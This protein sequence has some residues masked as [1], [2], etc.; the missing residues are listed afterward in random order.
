MT[1]AP[2]AGYRERMIEV[3][4]IGEAELERF[5]AGRTAVSPRDPITAAAF[6]D[7]RRQAEDMAWFLAL[8]DG[9][10]VGGG[11]VYVG[12]HS[13][14]GVGS[15]E[16]WTLAE[17]R[18]RGVGQ[19]LY[20]EL[21]R[22]ATDRGCVALDTR[23]QAD[24]PAGLAWTE[25]RGFRRIGA[26]SAST[27][28]L[29]S[30]AVPDVAPPDGITI[31]SWAERP[32]IEHALYTVFCEAT[33]DIP[34]QAGV[35][36][37]SFERWLANDMRGTSDRPDAVFVALAGDEVVGYAKLS[38]DDGDP[39]AAWND[40]CGV[41]RAWRGRGVAGALKRAQIAWAMSQ[42]LE[43]LHARNELANE[44]IRR[45]NERLGYLTEPGTIL[46]R[47]MLSSPD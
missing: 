15:A 39:E 7:W 10:D 21:L 41:R 43:R 22:W 47:T 23:V 8:E 34:G 6:A 18:G 19:A 4:E 5:V 12:W 31:Q 36:V 14:P 11:L 29:S 13:E 38:L 33:R 25:R 9:R 46:L 37:P 27:L 3:V 20:E 40:L 45:L 42:G 1:A 44:P 35:E 32:G 17:A 26:E 28:A 24:D 16:A 2:R 30:I